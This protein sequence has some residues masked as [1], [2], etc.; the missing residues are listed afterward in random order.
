[1]RWRPH[2]VINPECQMTEMTIGVKSLLVCIKY[3]V[4]YWRMGL[5]L[6]EVWKGGVTWLGYQLYI[7]CY[8]TRASF[9]WQSIAERDIIVLTSSYGFPLTFN[10]FY[11][12]GKLK[13]LS[14]MYWW[15]QVLLKET[16]REKGIDTSDMNFGKDRVLERA[17]F[18]PNFNDD[19]TIFMTP[20][21]LSGLKPELYWANHCSYFEG[22][23]YWGFL[24][25]L[26]KMI[27]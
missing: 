26:C 23:M 18:Y 5:Q 6:S 19:M 10:G 14:V 21:N 3:I 7:H 12:G 11:S 9:Y 20:R 8:H 13:L 27:C 4:R 25:R 2:L 17:H 16:K 22:M 15:K 1:M 24:L